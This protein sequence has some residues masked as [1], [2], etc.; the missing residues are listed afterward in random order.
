MN[1]KKGEATTKTDPGISDGKREY[2]EEVKNKKNQETRNNKVKI[3]E[4]TKVSID[5]KEKINTKQEL[6]ILNKEVGME[7]DSSDGE[8]KETLMEVD[9]EGSERGTDT[10]FKS[11]ITEEWLDETDLDHKHGEQEINRNKGEEEEE[12]ETREIQ[13]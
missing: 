13:G 11:V 6:E 9:E 8:K 10:D 1:T 2:E 4:I 7:E 12:V 3:R 5:I